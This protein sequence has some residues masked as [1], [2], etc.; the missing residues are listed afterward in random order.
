MKNKLK[1]MPYL[2]KTAL[3][4]YFNKNTNTLRNSISYWKKNKILIQI[5]RGFYVYRDFL[6]KDENALHYPRFLATKMIEPSYL[7]M[8]SV[9]QDYQILSDVVYNYSIVSL[10][11]TNSITNQFGIFNYRSIKDELFSGFSVEIYGNMKWYV[12]SKSKALFDYIYFKQNRFSEISKKELAGLRLNLELM[13]EKDWREYE[14]YLKKA[15]AKMM[16][17]YKLIRKEYAN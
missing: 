3:V 7:S 5:K 15:P 1:K 10:K 11:K 6:E 2:S 4:N 12:A 14:R 13:Q 8:E 16:S 17:I 9:L